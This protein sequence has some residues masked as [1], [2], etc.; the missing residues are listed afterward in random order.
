MCRGCNLPGHGTITGRYYGDG[1]PPPPEPPHPI[2]GTITVTNMDTLAV[3]RPREDSRGYFTITVPRGTYE[4]VARSRDIAGPIIRTVTVAAGNTVDA[5][6]GIH[7][8]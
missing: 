8:P 2:I 4:V 3:Y 1:G 7:A 5:D 6:L